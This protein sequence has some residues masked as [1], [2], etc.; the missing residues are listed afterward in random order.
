VKIHTGRGEDDKWSKWVKAFISIDK[1]SSKYV[2][3]S[4]QR[5]E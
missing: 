4:I 5:Q 1:S 3:I 2:L